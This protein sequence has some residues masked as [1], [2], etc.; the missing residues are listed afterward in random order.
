MGILLL[1]WCE[2]EWEIPHLLREIIKRISRL[3]LF[4]SWW[5]GECGRTFSWQDFSFPLCCSQAQSLKMIE[6]NEKNGKLKWRKKK[7][8]ERVD[9]TSKYVCLWVWFS[10]YVSLVIKLKRNYCLFVKEY[11]HNYRPKLWR[12]QTL[13]IIITFLS[14]QF[15]P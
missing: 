11:F 15:R 7:E 10:F 14:D 6:K 13:L 4:F 1:S 9:L 3:L 12:L 5:F 8:R 2:W